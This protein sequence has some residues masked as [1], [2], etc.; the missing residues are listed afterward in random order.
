MGFIKNL[1]GG[2]N[3]KGKTK[4]PAAAMKQAGEDEVTI[5]GGME[6]KGKAIAR[7]L[8]ND[9]N[10]SAAAAAG[11]VGNLMLESGLQPDNV[12]NGKGFQDGPINNIPVGTQRVGY[13]YG[14]WTND[15]LESSVVGW[16][17]AVR[18]TSLQPT[19]TTTS[20][21]CTNFVVPSLSVTTGRAAPLSLRTTQ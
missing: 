9:L 18:Q 7:R 10:I 2:G 16:S 8:M 4:S 20:I 12:E 5:S 19:K 13:G 3:D 6:T 17:S 21:S 15:R 1:F 14:Q 11:I